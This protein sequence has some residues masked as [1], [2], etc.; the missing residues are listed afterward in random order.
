[1]DLQN[2]KYEDCMFDLIICSHVLEHIENDRKAISELVRILKIGGQALIL[3]PI[4]DLAS[5]YEAPWITEPEDRLLHFG[6][7]THLRKYG[8]DFSERL[9]TY[10]NLPLSGVRVIE[11]EDFLS[12]IEIEKMR[13]KDDVI[14]HLLK[15]RH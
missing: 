14:F 10:G 11:A 7:K 12:E 13:I 1:M 8:R 5:T 3:V 6:E 4:S 15:E 9:R 2:T